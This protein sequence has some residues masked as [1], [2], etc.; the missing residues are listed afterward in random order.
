MKMGKMPL[1]RKLSDREKEE[2]QKERPPFMAKK[3]IEFTE[4]PELYNQPNTKITDFT[5]LIYCIWKIFN[6]S[7]QEEYWGKQGQ[8][9]DNFGETL[10]SFRMDCEAVLDDSDY[11]VEMTSKQRKML[12]ELLLIVEDYSGD[13]NTPLSRYGENDQA[14]INDPS[15]QEIGRYA[16]KVYEELSGDNLDQWE[17][18]KTR[19]I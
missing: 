5:P 12:T 11:A 3:S 9:G 4:N 18:S 2:I 7:Y 13:K 1:P 15:W 14:I 10:E 6:K 8:W 19:N 16:R 17:R